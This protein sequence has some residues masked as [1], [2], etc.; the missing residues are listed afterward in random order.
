[1]THHSSLWD[2]STA[3]NIYFITALVYS[4]NPPTGVSISLLKVVCVNL[5]P[6]GKMRLSFPLNPLKPESNPSV[7]RC[8]TR[9]VTGDFV[10]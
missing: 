7:Q 2:N 8:L 10:S 4:E 9:F 3:T 1:V 6:K 5:S